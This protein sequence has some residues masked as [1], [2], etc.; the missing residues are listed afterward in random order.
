MGLHHHSFGYY[1]PAAETVRADKM[2]W[3]AVFNRP[4]PTGLICFV[5]EDEP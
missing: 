1:Q 4:M 5:Q 3:I 2:N